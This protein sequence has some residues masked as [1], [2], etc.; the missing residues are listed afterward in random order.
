MENRIEKTGSIAKTT[1]FAGNYER[2]TKND[3]VTQFYFIHAAKI[4]FFDYYPVFQN[5]D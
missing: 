3:T 2:V 4:N 5:N 1:I